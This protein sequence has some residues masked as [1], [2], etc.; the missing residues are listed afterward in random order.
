MFDLEEWC[1]INLSGRRNGDEFS[2]TCP[3]CN[4]AGKF[5]VNL[6]KKLFRCFRSSCSA[7][8]RAWQL[9]SHVEGKS[10]TEARK[11]VGTEF[12]NS[13][14]PAFQKKKPTQ[15]LLWDIPLPEEFIP[16]YLA[17]RDPEYRVIKSLSDRLSNE[18]LKTFGVGFCK[19]GPCYH[20]SVI[21]VVSEHGRAWTARDATENWKTDEKRSKYY[22]PRGAWAKD[23]LFGW[24]FYEPG[25]DLV[26]VEGPFDVMKLW[27]HGISAVALLGKE[28]GKGQRAQLLS[29]PSST[30]IT[31]LIDPEEKRW[32]VD[33]IVAKL[34]L[35]F[36]N[37]MKGKL[38]TGVDPGDST[39]QQAFLAIDQAV[40][41]R[42]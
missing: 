32:T 13:N 42:P 9:V 39:K 8:G 24:E 31:I 12:D 22:N 6:E 35:K 11:L 7:S 19:N 38:P 26:I 5:S 18:T 33:D 36:R 15:N 4:R 21:P 23:L 27:E 34:V 37:L 14:V 28:L 30:Y 1:D 29:L 20:R 16:C 40:R 41:I 10:G 17:G 25:A 3:Y 2:A